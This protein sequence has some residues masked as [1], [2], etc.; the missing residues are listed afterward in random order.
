MALMAGTTE[1]N[2]QQPASI[3]TSANGRPVSSALCE[4]CDAALATLKTKQLSNTMVKAPAGPQL[5]NNIYINCSP[6]SFDIYTSSRYKNAMASKIDK[7]GD[8]WLSLISKI[9]KDIVPLLQTFLWFTLISVVLLVYRKQ[10]EALVEAIRKRVESGS[11]L[12]VG[13]VSI[14]ADLHPQSPEQQAIK[15]KQEVTEATTTTTTAAPVPPNLSTRSFL[16]EDLALRVIQSEYGVPINR[17]LQAGQNMTFD[18]VFAKDKA[19]YI[20]QVKYSRGT[21]STSRALMQITQILAGITKYHWKN[22]TLILAVVFDDSVD[23]EMEQRRLSEAVK[24]CGV[25]VDVRCFSFKHLAKQFG[26]EP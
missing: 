9:A 4:P 7:K 17:Q 2:Q 11:G 25:M 22:V 15:V 26:V 24:D 10:I 12:K 5:C 23:L 18:G 13:F 14:E 16:A 19:S 8:G 3:A 1:A 20:V 21:Y 6:S